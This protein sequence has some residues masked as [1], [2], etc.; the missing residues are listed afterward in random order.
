MMPSIVLRFADLTRRTPVCLVKTYDKYAEMFKKF[1]V[2]NTGLLAAARV[3]AILSKSQVC[4]CAKCPPFCTA[5]LFLCILSFAAFSMSALLSAFP[6]SKGS[7]SFASSAPFTSSSLHVT[8]ESTC[9]ESPAPLFPIGLLTT[10]SF[11]YAA[12]RPCSL[13]DLEAIGH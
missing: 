5:R 4:H 8:S 10:L 6:P 11:V 2:D 3:H 9:F 12:C 1:D 7:S 13:K